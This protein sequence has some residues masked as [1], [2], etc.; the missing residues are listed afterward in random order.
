MRILRFAV[1]G[2][3]L[4]CFYVF[5]KPSSYCVDAASTMLIEDVRKE[6][7]F[8]KKKSSVEHS[9][10]FWTKNDSLGSWLVCLEFEECSVQSYH[11]RKKLLMLRPF[12]G[13][14]ENIFST[15]TKWHGFYRFFFTK[16][17]VV[18]CIFFARVITAIDFL[19][20]LYHDVIT[21]ENLEFGMKR[22]YIIL[23]AVC[24][25]TISITSWLLQIH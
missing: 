15:F 11:R 23:N 24:S 2:T 1:F 10:F 19:A 16:A 6:V 5:V 18:Q 3:I 4:S 25:V 12:M 8:I 14:T 21:L 17:I 20:L 7:L 9:E 22:P 13:Y